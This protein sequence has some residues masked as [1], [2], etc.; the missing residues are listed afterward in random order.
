MSDD[1]ECVKIYRCTECGKISTSVGYLHGHAEGHRGF[2]WP[3]QVASVD[4]LME[5]TE[6]YRIPVGELEEFAVEDDSYE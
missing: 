2:L 3:W 5:Y 6:T 4:A 1:S